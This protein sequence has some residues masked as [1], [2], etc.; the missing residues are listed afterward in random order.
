MV[1]LN[2]LLLLEWI[3]CSASE[4]KLNMPEGVLKKIVKTKEDKQRDLEEVGLNSFLF[5]YHLKLF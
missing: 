3:R 2:V 5:C 1:L 4:E